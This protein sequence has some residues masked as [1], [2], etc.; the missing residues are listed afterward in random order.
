MRPKL[1]FAAIAALL[2]FGAWLASWLR[3]EF[4]AAWMYSGTN[5]RPVVAVSAHYFGQDAS[6]GA[7]SQHE[8]ADSVPAR[9]AIAGEPFWMV[10]GIVIDQDG[11][12][13]NQGSI[14]IISSRD[15]AIRAAMSLENGGVFAWSLDRKQWPAEEA[16][17]W[18]TDGMGRRV[19]SGLVKLQEGM[20]IGVVGRDSPLW[21]LPGTLRFPADIEHPTGW[22]ALSSTK[23]PSHYLA[24]A[25]FSGNPAKV[26]LEYNLALDW[27][28]SDPVELQVMDEMLNVQA[29]AACA[30][31]AEAR[32]L[33]ADGWHVPVRRCVLH[34]P[35]L[36]QGMAAA[37]YSIACNGRF[38]ARPTPRSG[39]PFEVLWLGDG[40]FGVL[41]VAQGDHERA[42]GVIAWHE[43]GQ[44]EHGYVE[45]RLALPGSISQ[46]LQLLDE[47][48]QPLPQVMVLYS[49][50]N[51]EDP[52]MDRT[53]S[54]RLE[55]D[56]S[57]AL[58]MHGF[59]P[60]SYTFHLYHPG[61]S[62]SG[63]SLD[64]QIP[65]PDREVRVGWTAVVWVAPKLQPG[66]EELGIYSLYYRAANRPDQSWK[67]RIVDARV[68]FHSFRLRPGSYDVWLFR[69]PWIGAGRIEVAEATA[70]QDHAIEMHFSSAIGGQVVQANGTPM[71]GRIVRL[72]ERGG[73]TSPF[74]WTEAKTDAQGS[75][76]LV[77]E[78]LDP[79]A[80]QVM[81]ATGASVVRSLPCADGHRVVVD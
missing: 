39:G 46:E 58:A 66:L 29:T 68:G 45:W 42:Y 36:P 11:A 31:I 50:R 23:N 79:D 7:H 8:Q 73:T 72:V 69:D 16:S 80:I 59:V 61:H 28:C 40:D 12:R 63:Y 53:F 37:S 14:T 30:T 43:P 27:T 2:V 60:G 44:R 49:L 78:G 20:R 5:P 48:G 54:G 24:E 3:E 34:F 38:H 10:G 57:G 4:E 19:H 52:R 26:T 17:V 67:R 81:D 74:E 18:I 1:L 71:A 32:Q 33:L 22:I 64:I 77:T 56:H 41:G 13:F 9:A 65:S 55:S 47:A 35:L 21:Q 6:P 62:H 76:V 70:R 75:Y 25:R 51:P 15:E